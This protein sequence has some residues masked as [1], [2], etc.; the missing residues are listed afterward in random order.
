MVLNPK[1]DYQYLINKFLHLKNFVSKVD[2]QISCFVFWAALV[3]VFSLYFAIIGLIGKKDA[4]VWEIISISAIVIYGT[5]MF[6]FMCLWADRISCSTAS[7]ARKAHFL[8]GNSCPTGLHI[9]F[10]LALSQDVHFTVWG[11]FPLKR[12]FV[13]ASV[14]AA[15]TYSVL[16]KD[17][18]K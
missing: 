10:L 1:P 14:G 15:I 17:I 2:S 11:F 5:F 18:T 12:S 13:L 7:I 16:I 8:Q 4:S 3:N 6:F 9:R